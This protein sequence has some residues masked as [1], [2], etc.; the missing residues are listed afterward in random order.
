MTDCL[1]GRL[2]S[3]PARASARK[4]AS[5]DD[6]TRRKTSLTTLVQNSNQHNARLIARE[7]SVLDDEHAAQAEALTVGELAGKSAGWLG[8]LAA[9]AAATVDPEGSIRRR[10]RAEREEARV[11]FWREHSG[12]CALA[13]YG[14]PTDA[15]LA[16]N[17]N[18]AARARR[19]KKAKVDPD[20]TMDR[21]RVL[22]FLDLA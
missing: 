7:L 5:T 14:L 17:A 9:Q 19:Y 16:A 22:A 8:K 20:A 6:E 12:A 4:R 2:I 15:A 11:R 21:L 10:E 3:P 13:A 1:G 18:I